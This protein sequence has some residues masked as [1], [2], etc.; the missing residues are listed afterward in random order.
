M[1]ADTIRSYDR[2]NLVTDDEL[3]LDKASYSNKKSGVVCTLVELCGQKKNFAAIVCHFPINTNPSGISLRI[4]VSPS[5]VILKS[6]YSAHV[7]LN[8]FACRSVIASILD[9]AT[10]WILLSIL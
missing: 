3:Q 1:T 4:R 9:N 7:M 6:F 8:V 2:T 5:D 10:R